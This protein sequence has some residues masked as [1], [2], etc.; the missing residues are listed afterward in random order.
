MLSIK[1]AVREQCA[2]LPVCVVCFCCS[3]LAGKT[4]FSAKKI[5]ENLVDRTVDDSFIC[6]DRHSGKIR[7][8]NERIDKIHF[9][10][11]EHLP[12]PK[13]GNSTIT[14]GLCLRIEIKSS[15]VKRTRPHHASRV[16]RVRVPWVGC[17]RSTGT[18]RT[19]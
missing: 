19:G 4:T 18:P 5:N 15:L 14:I 12:R 17:H 6:S 7:R 1:Q 13:T 2:E 10:A 8:V 9:P 16:S 11:N 3:V